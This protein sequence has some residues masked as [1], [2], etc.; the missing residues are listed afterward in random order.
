VCELQVR[1]LLTT[2]ELQVREA[3]RLC[4]VTK[5]RLQTLQAQQGEAAS[6]AARFGGA[7]G[8]GGAEG[9][10]LRG[11]PAGAAAAGS[12]NLSHLRQVVERYIL[13]DDGEETDALFQVLFVVIHMPCT[14][15]AMRAIAMYAHAHVHAHHAQHAHAYAHAHAHVHVHVCVCSMFARRWRSHCK[16]C[17]TLRV[18]THSTHA[19]MY[20]VIAT[21]LQFDA[22]TVR[23]LQAARQRKGAAQRGLIG[24]ASL[25][26]SQR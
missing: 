13:M 25:L 19:A 11:R 16:G 22:A 1:L 26:F 10:E 8:A 6:Q 2:Y 24:R 23:E 9:A 7:D 15:Y 14:C 3:R 17:C 4:A 5:A 21:F 12:H 20:Q 18:R